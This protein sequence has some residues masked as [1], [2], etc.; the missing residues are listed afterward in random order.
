M[1]TL[2]SISVVVPVYNEHE[3]LRPLAEELLPVVRSLG[4]PAEVIFVD[5]G[6]QD[7]SLEVLE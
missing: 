2:S 3:S 1:S 4:R 6:S 7:G 5:D